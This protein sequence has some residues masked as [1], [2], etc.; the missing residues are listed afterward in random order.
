LE[1]ERIAGKDFTTLG[2]IRTIRD[3]NSMQGDVR[4]KVHRLEGGGDKGRE[5]GERS[6][7]VR[8]SPAA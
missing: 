5:R 4:R 2:N 6:Y 1:V 3:E 7:D 8:Q